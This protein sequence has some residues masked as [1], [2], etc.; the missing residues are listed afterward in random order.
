MYMTLLAA[1]QTLIHRYTGEDDIVVGSPIANRNRHEIETLI[2]FF[3]NTLVMRSDLSGNP[4][5]SQLLP[6]VREVALGA[7]AH[8][9]LPFE[10]LVEEL[11]PERDLSRTPFFQVF[12]NMLQFDA[13]VFHLA[14]L[15]ITPVA[16]GVAESKFDLTMYVIEEGPTIRL[17][18]D[19]NADLFESNTIGDILS[20][21]H[22]LLDGIV[23]NPNR[24]ISSYALISREQRGRVANRGN[25]TAP[26]DSFVEF[27]KTA[28]EQSVCARFEQQA[29]SFPS[30]LAVKSQAHRWSYAELNRQAN[31]IAH[32]LLRHCGH[33]GQR[34]AL[35]FDHGAPM[36]AA[37]LGV[38][39]S[40]NA[41][42]PLDPSHPQDRIAFMGED[43]QAAIL[44]TDGENYPR[45]VSF[46]N[47]NRPV[48]NVDAIDVAAST[49]N[50]AVAVSP[51]ALAYILYT[52]GS[53]GQPKG[54]M[55]NHRNVL[56]HLRC[57]SNNLHIAADDKL[58][59]LS[60]YGFDAAVMDILA[61]LLNGATLYPLDLKAQ[62]SAAV[63]R[64][65]IE[66]AV[67]IYHSTPTVYRYLFAGLDHRDDLSAIRLVVLGGEEAQKTDFDLF[68]THCSKE[69]ILVNGLGP[70]ESTLA[71]QYFMTHESQLAGHRLPVGYPV[72]DTEIV[73][74]DEAGI[75]AEVCGE[76]GIRSAH[77]ALGY[78]QRPE[79]SEAAF[80]MD[81]QGGP[82]RLYRTG[83]MGRRLPDGSIGFLGRRDFQVKIRGLRIELGEIEAALGQHPAVRS[84]VVLVRADGAGEKQLT[85]YVVGDNC[86][87]AASDLRAHL[88]A[89]L[90]DYMVPSAF[91]ILEQ[92]PLTRNGKIDRSALPAP[93]RRRP[94]LEETLAASR[95]PRRG[96]RGKY[97]G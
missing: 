24:P 91:V 10:K 20:Y 55:Q 77:V 33:G 63:R 64:S 68:K 69:C 96:N 9:D 34:V 67:T 1:F 49:E 5:F 29:R 80:R 92:L 88:K 21:Y 53:T 30:K 26:G 65:I 27:T 54:V 28:I 86:V 66:E 46:G 45:A 41:Y 2:G 74:L 97:M 48:V 52:S 50:P 6:R 37:I 3:I 13:G 59:L 14:G 11:Q 79:L 40:A 36:I 82:R 35:L 56:H 12:F 22:T 15:A 17:T 70:T 95:N 44:L 62:D 78:W 7:Y 75:D 32:T 25:P 61:A 60:S 93:N 81:P 51:D 76:I 90:P 73:L 42:V 38:L 57:Y 16:T 4:I 8:Q 85:G 87:P 71:L 83:D 94:E 18:V 43:C 23:E 31:R 39:K 72:D 47:E 19:Y 89:K 58:T 84:A